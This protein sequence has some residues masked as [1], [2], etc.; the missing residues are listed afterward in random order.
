MARHVVLQMT[1]DHEEHFARRLPLK[2]D[3]V[4][5]HIRLLSHS[6]V[7]HEPHTSCIHRIIVVEDGVRCDDWHVD[8]LV[9]FKLQSFREALKEN[10]IYLVH[11]LPPCLVV[12]TEELAYADTE[13]NRDAIL[14]EILPQVCLRSESIAADIP[15][16]SHHC[17]D[18]A[19][20]GGEG[21]KPKDEN[22]DGEISL[23][24]VGRVDLHGRG[25]ELRQ[26]P[27]QCNTILCDDICSIYATDLRPSLGIV[28]HG[29]DQEP[30]AGY[31]MIE[32]DHRD[33]Q[34]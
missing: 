13:I 20:K 27:M 15:E 17:G 32:E 11:P 12:L 2:K 14:I 28:D 4:R 25:H 34:L 21:D 29:S 19:H 9:Q 6:E 30:Q 18:A 33:N 16:L 3:R 10:D 7:A 31:V 26:A 23:A 8:L 24:N 22:E 1:S 5:G